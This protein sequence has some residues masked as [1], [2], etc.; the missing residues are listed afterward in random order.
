MRKARSIELKLNM[1]IHLII[2]YII[3]EFGDDRC[4]GFSSIGSV[5]WLKYHFKAII[6]TIELIT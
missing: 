2:K 1:D 4:F 6:C 5:N 3:A